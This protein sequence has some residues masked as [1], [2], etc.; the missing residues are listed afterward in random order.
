MNC[1]TCGKRLYKERVIVGGEPDDP[2]EDE[3]WTCKH[4]GYEEPYL[5]E[6]FSFVDDEAQWE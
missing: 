5:A 3:M 4:C 6:P 2:M 1:P